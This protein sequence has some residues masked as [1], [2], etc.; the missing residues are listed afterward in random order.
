MKTVCKSNPTATE[1]I[2]ARTSRVLQSIF[3]NR[4]HW[5]THIDPVGNHFKV[6]IRLHDDQ[7]TWSREVV[8]DTHV[9]PSAVACL[10][11][12]SKS[13]CIDAIRA[14][15]KTASLV[16]IKAEQ[17]RK[18]LKDLLFV[19]FIKLDDKGDAEFRFR[20]SGTEHTEVFLV[21]A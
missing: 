10:H 21:A 3:E 1:R 17:V 5:S 7:K 8:L 20:I 16:E 15:L 9:T 11:S 2:V 14:A 19:E 18:A 6:T 12:V 4:V 13:E